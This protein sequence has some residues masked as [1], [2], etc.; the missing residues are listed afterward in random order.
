MNTDDAKFV[1][2]AYRPGDEKTGTSPVF[3]EAL[4]QAHRD[5][6]LLQWLGRQQAFDQAMGA[7]IDGIAP[8]AGLRRAILIGSRVSR[9]RIRPWWR[10]PVVLAAAAAVVAAAGIPLAFHA[11]ESS[12]LVA[13]ATPADLARFVVTNLTEGPHGHPEG[14]AVSA[15]EQALSEHRGSFIAMRSPEI[16]PGRFSATG[17]Q[18]FRVAGT[19]I[20]EVCFARDGAWFHLFVARG[21]GGSDPGNRPA[22]PPTILEVGDL[23]AATWEHAGN[24]YTLAT[25]SGAAALR[26]LL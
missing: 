4:E 24:F 18:E 3:A 17:C 5:P 21:P 15:L 8:P 6:A 23:A 7:K 14:S 20:F 16:S 11:P 26:P 9:R 22:A 1:L 2:R 25:R 10:S 12:R 13:I 19:E